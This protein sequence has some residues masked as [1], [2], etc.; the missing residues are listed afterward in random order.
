MIQELLDISYEQELKK[1]LEAR[2]AELTP[3]FMEILTQ[4]VAKTDA[5]EEPELNNRLQIIYQQA[6]R[7]S[8]QANL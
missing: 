8:M 1:Q 7:I 3:E 2:K 5:S 4:L 6:L